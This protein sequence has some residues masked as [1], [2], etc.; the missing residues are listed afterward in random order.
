MS[1]DANL[2]TL[3][4]LMIASEADPLVKVGGLGDVAGSLPQALRA[5]P[6]EKIGGF[7]LDARL[8]IPFHSVIRDRKSVV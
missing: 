5:L 3:R 8:A 1:A 4:I 2:K 7:T 6:A